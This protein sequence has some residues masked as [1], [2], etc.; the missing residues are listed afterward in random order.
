M[1][2]AINDKGLNKMIKKM[3]LALSL[4]SCVFSSSYAGSVL[5]E[6]TGVNPSSSEEPV[7]AGSQQDMKGGSDTLDNQAFASMTKKLMPLTPNQIT[8]LH[9]DELR[10]KKAIESSPVTPP[11]PTSNTLLVNLSPGATPHTIRMANG[12]IST[13]NFV[14]STGQ[15]WPVE[16]YDLGDPKDFSVK[17]ST[18][19]SSIFI[20]PTSDFTMANIAVMLKNLSTPI[21]FT[22]IPG[23]KKVDY[24]DDIHVPGQGPNAMPGQSQLPPTES[25][26]LSNV[27]DGIPPSGSKEFSTSSPGTMVWRLGGRLFVRTKDHVISPS[28]ISTMQSPDGMH[29][30]E[31]MDTPVLLALENGNTVNITIGDKING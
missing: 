4:A 14:D 10:T 22:L 6:I 11:Q 29:A 9:A 27:L 8:I 12:Y 31:M 30:Y 26:S 1:M 23:Q 16:S 13:L 19:G 17:T 20:Q 7:E 5:G 28:W 2:Y 21:M 25:P 18:D 3:L 15:V 24:R